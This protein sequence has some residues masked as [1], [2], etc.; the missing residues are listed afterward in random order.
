MG[1]GGCRPRGEAG[2]RGRF[3]G[4]CGHGPARRARAPPNPDPR[5]S[6]PPR[7][8]EALEWLEGHAIYSKAEAADMEERARAR[9]EARGAATKWMRLKSLNARG[10]C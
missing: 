9:V 1:R 7:A 10:K 2:R 6:A 8:G 4:A 5:T 3:S